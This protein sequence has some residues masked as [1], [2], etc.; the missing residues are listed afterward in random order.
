MAIT[1]DKLGPQ[2]K[3]AEMGRVVNCLRV[4]SDGRRLL[5]GGMGF[6]A[7]FSLAG[8]SPE[9]VTKLDTSCRSIHV[10]SADWLLLNQGMHGLTLCAV[11]TTSLR[12]DATY[13]P[14]TAI[15]RV[16]ISPDGLH[17]LAMFQPPAGFALLDIRI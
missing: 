2:K 14:A 7:L 15:E 16:V 8:K 12:L 17:A 11:G 9:L 10:L 6:V 5:A 4:T 13:K 1:A 3:I